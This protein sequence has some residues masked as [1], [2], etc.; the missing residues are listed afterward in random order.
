MEDVLKAKFAYK[1]INFRHMVMTSDQIGSSKKPYQNDK[2]FVQRTFDLGLKDGKAANGEMFEHAIE[3][4]KLMLMADPRIA[5][6]T[7]SS[8]IEA[9]TDGKFLEPE[10]Q[11]NSTSST[12]GF[13]DES[14]KCRAIVLAGGGSWGAYEVGVLKGFTSDPSKADDFKYD[15]V[16]GVSAGSINAMAVA[17]WPI[18]Q[19]KDMAEWASGLWANLKTSNVF[20]NW[21]PASVVT[22]VLEKSGIF[23]D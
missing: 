11:V 7:L 20:Q 1:D 19:E 8:F 13:L 2:D 12:E 14:K 10:P 18:G 21:E 5:G 17:A 3:M 22:G 15:V 6:H 16:T 9:K 23:D 4:H